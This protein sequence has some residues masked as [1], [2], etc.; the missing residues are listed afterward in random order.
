VF[1]FEMPEAGL[2]H[3][4]PICAS[5]PI[6]VERCRPLCP[7]IGNLG[8]CELCAWARLEQPLK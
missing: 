5:L 3:D 8:T 7:A 2:D 4:I 1:I 6:W